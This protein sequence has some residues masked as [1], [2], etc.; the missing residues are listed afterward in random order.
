MDAEAALD[1][2]GARRAAG[3][4][5]RNPRPLLDL[6]GRRWALHHLGAAGPR[7]HFPGVW[8]SS[9]ARRSRVTGVPGARQR[10]GGDSMLVGLRRSSSDRRRSV[11]GELKFVL[12]TEEGCVDHATLPIYEHL[13]VGAL[14]WSELRAVF[15]HASEPHHLV[16]ALD[17]SYTNESP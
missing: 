15:D 1:G 7:A 5:R 13:D 8:S 11:P 4:R 2:C 12:A 16:L 3:G 14:P 6:L 9:S 10:T 17:P